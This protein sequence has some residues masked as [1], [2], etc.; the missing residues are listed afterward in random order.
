MRNIFAIGGGD[1]AVGETLPIDREILKATKKK[2]PKALFIPTASGDSQAYCDLF[3]EIYGNQLGCKVDFLFLIRNESSYEEMQKKIATAD[4]IYVGTGNSLMMMRKW[5]FTGLDK[6]LFKASEKG[7]ILAGIG[8]GALCWFEHGHSEAMKY[9]QANSQSENWDYI[10]VKCL[11]LVDRFMLCP[12]FDEAKI[13]ESFT[14]MIKRMG[15]IG[16]GLEK[17]CA[18]QIK[19]KNFRI[20]GAEEA[21]KAHGIIKVRANIVHKIV[22]ADGRWQRLAALRSKTA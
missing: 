13:A 15:G 19:G 12:S 5:R 7:T 16:I 20:I 11:R 6:L 9:Y 18:I 2:S 1:L 3:E 21:V 10:R 4:L 8:A 22:K 14:D 17:N